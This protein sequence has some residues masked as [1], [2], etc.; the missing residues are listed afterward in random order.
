MSTP[1]VSVITVTYNNLEGVK[2]TLESVRSQT[3]RDFEWVVIDGA[4]SD[5][6]QAY[7]AEV[8]APGFR[9]ISE[10]DGG[11]Y[12]AM[13]KGI[14]IASGQYA[15][16]MNAGDQFASDEVIADFMDVVGADRPA[17]VYGDALEQ[18][19]SGSF[20]KPARP[21]SQNAYV[22]FTHHQAI[23][24]EM[25]ILKAK[26]YDETYRFGSDW[27]LTTRVLKDHPGSHLKIDK[28]ICVFE[29]GGVSQRDDHRKQINH[30]HWRI[31][32]E[33]GKLPLPTAAFFWLLKTQTNNV[34]RALPRLYDSIRYKKQLSPHD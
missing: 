32:R 30:E 11:I 4:S 22:M 6:T 2:K 15:I 29:R 8:E 23:F 27:A 25:S 16:F 7:L 31:Y 3:A 12:N 28:P 24:Y 33:L 14:A 19:E 34:R 9:W 1:M 17:L 26:G 20:Y 13:N 18:G 5:G 10:K 21:P